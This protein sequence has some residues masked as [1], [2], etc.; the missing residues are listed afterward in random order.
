MLE[1]FTVYPKKKKEDMHT[2][3]FV[4]SHGSFQFKYLLLGLSNAPGAYSRLIDKA[5]EHLPADFRLVYIDDVIIYGK[6]VKRTSRMYYTGPRG[7]C[8]CGY[9]T[10]LEEMPLFSRMG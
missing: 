3:S 1:H 2:T 9:E 8:C 10:Q 4:S 6:N 5:L 7:T